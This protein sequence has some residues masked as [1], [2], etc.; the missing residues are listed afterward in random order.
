MMTCARRRSRAFTLA[1]TLIA[2]AVTS[3]IMVAVGSAVVIASRTMPDQ[4]SPAALAIDA[5]SALEQL[6]LELQYA[7]HLP[8]Y[9]SRRITFTLADRNDDG[10][11]ERVSWAW[12][13]IAGDPLTRQYND[14]LAVPMLKDVKNFAFTYTTSNVQ[15]RY[16]G[17]L[18]EQSETLL[19]SYTG[20]LL[21]LLPNSFQITSSNWIGQYIQPSLPSAA[22]AWRPTRV[23]FQARYSGSNVGATKVQLRS[24]D[25]Y[26]RPTTEILAE[27]TMSENTLSSGWSWNQFIYPN[28][29]PLSAD[30]SVALVLQWV[31]DTVSAEILYQSENSG[32]LYT[33]D[34]GATWT[35]SSSAMEYRLYGHAL[36]EGTTQSLTRTYF[37]TVNVAVELDADTALATTTAIN[38]L[39]TPEQLS[40]LWEADFRHN[41]LALDV[42]IDD[43]PDWVSGSAF[44][45]SSISNGVWRVSQPIQTDPL[46]DFLEPITVRALMR[47]ALADGGYSLLWINA[48]VSGGWAASIAATIQRQAD[49]TQKLTISNVVD[50]IW[51][52]LLTAERLPQEM[53]DVR[54]LIVPSRDT[55][56]VRVNDQEQGT[57]TY[58]TTEEGSG[59]VSLQ[60]AGT[61]AEFD[62]VSVRVGGTP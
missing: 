36:V 15:E 47:H 27:Q 30:E 21:S 37:T 34:G 62:Y 54:L 26:N 42:N 52:T 11:P 49:G 46:N 32:R 55:V 43:Q 16:P 20:S 1:E 14:G 31:Q 9:E 61:N 40:A 58:R 51:I 48:D 7:I 59:V 12:S 53:V 38:L 35:L 28:V 57:F 3:I 56:N 17:P 22:V 25:A 6:G 41:P 44:D 29:F 5:G 24:V 39:N 18:V 4:D 45:A 60:S 50:G 8:V 33:T 23:S 13:G 19:A 10:S 2:V